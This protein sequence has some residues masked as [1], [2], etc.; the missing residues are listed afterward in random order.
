[1]DPITKATVPF[2]KPKDSQNQFGYTFGGPIR[3]NKLFFFTDFERTVERKLATV[4][5][6]VPTDA[7]RAGDFSATGT[8]IYDSNT[9]AANG[10]GRT[11]FAGNQ[12]PTARS[13]PASFAMISLF[14]SPN[15][16]VNRYNYFAC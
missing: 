13:G 8:T 15:L 7:L 16:S 4:L 10:T 14:P 9:G 1:M 12:I 2:R 5:T 3:K 6:T 11:A